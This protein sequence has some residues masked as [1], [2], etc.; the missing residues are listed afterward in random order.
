MAKKLGY[1]TDLSCSWITKEHGEEWLQWQQ[2][3]AE[4]LQGQDFSISSKLHMIRHFM[5]YLSKY[6]GYS[7]AV[8]SMFR[9]HSS[10]HKVSSEE[11]NQH[12]IQNGV[13]A[14]NPAIILY[15]MSL[16]DFI[17][18][19][20]FSEEDDNGDVILLF[21]NP[22]V[23]LVRTYKTT[24]TVH[25]PLPY[26][27]MQQLRHIL[28]P[29]KKSQEAS[30]SPWRKHHFSDWTW[31]IEKLEFGNYAWM[32]VPESLI[33]VNDPDCIWRMREANR[34]IDKSHTTV[35]IY[36]IWSPAMAMFLLT[37]L[38]LPLRSYQVRF[39]DSGEG[40]TWRYENG[41]WVKNSKYRFTYGSEKR[42]YS[43]GVFKRIYDS[44][45]ESYSTGLY[46]TTNKTADRNRTEVDRGYTIPWQ[47]EELLYWLEKLRNWQ[48]KYNPIH[49]LTPA[50]KLKKQHFGDFKS[51]VQKEAMGEF[52]FL[53]RNASARP[54]ERS[55]PLPKGKENN[56]WYRLL[57]K[58]GDDV[59]AS[60]QT[61]SDGTKIQF[62]KDYGDDFKNLSH[63]CV[64]KFPLHSLRVSL[65]TCYT[66]DTDLPLPV[67]SKLLAGHTRL[68]MTIYYNKI[69]PSVMAEKLKEA[70]AALIEK[71][72]QSLKAF[73]LD[74]DLSQIEMRAV[75]L[76]DKY[77]TALNIVSNRNLAGWEER[78]C[79]ICL[80]GGNTTRSE[81][82]KTVGGCWNGGHL[83]ED[84]KDVNK[85]VYA[86]VPHG[87][88]NCQ[89][90]RWFA[91]DASYLPQ[92]NSHFNQISYKAH[93]AA[94]LSVEIEGKLE[95]LKD[96]QYLCEE[97]GK[98]FT[99]HAK[100][101]SFERRYE[102]Q[103]VEADEY[104]KDYIATF[105]LIKRIIEIENQRDH[106]DED[107][108]LVAVGSGDDVEVC[109]NFIET[110]SELLH[111]S[112]LCNDAE[113][114]P[115]I[116]DD[117]R[118][119]PVIEK[120][121]RFLDRMM[122]QRGYQPIFLEMDEKTA[123]IAGNALFRKMA[124]I[125]NPDDKIEGFKTASNYIEAQQYMVDAKLLEEGVSE[126][127]QQVPILLKPCQSKLI[128]FKEVD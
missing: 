99:K 78:A 77:R 112:L 10:G 123:L 69:T 86:P 18:K 61:L 106:D 88:G 29:Y 120:R 46:I 68:L 22:F 37:K 70:D 11:F 47:H 56:P 73:L 26:R 115:E 100:L 8:A 20:H 52:S 111:L 41:N 76:H 75:F 7:Y 67:I 125:A 63:M 83:I 15:A 102:K 64:T 3:I 117:L 90:C 49:D 27:Y 103:K 16:C 82:L 57:S 128:P 9:G 108:K 121:N 92:L 72:D 59:W 35:T 122:A 96:E 34:K 54:A 39:L 65:I 55:F 30:T 98:P 91:T 85:R 40:D 66:M 62:V 5:C 19:E 58:L 79:G 48:E 32:E 104:A 6:V 114:Y 71:S 25:S 14:Q 42:P 23:K 110:D 105:N 33:D 119:T 38:H 31:A 28:C 109:M 1:T 50:T 87:P 84:T 2:Y 53:F 116:K 81:E 51:R 13:N 21:K 89:R 95:T 12:L 93:Q 80:V 107:Q 113:F 124:Q 97:D 36:E 118:K 4:W 94:R 45:S 127:T 101:Q 60:G 24:E 43:K 126:L 74:A 44:M 17:L